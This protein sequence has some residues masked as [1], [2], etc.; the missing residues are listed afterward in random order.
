MPG[1]QLAGAG[2]YRLDHPEIAFHRIQNKVS[3]CG[4]IFVRGVKF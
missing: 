2:Q 3:V 4:E 1:I